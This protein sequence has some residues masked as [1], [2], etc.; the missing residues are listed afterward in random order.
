MPS[1]K[2]LSK[3]VGGLWDDDDDES[4]AAGDGKPKG[5]GKTSGSQP[6]DPADETTEA[7]EQ[8]V[9]MPP[10]DPLF[11]TAHLLKEDWSGEPSMVLSL[12]MEN[13]GLRGPALEVIGAS[14][15]F[16]LDIHRN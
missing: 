14:N 5:E 8:V 10:R 2:D 9:S 13:C 7:A 12:R 16:A 11:D 6:V 4:D 15:F 3:P 1:K